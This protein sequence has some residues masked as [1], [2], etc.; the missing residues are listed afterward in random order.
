MLLKLVFPT[1]LVKSSLPTIQKPPTAGPANTRTRVVLLQVQ[2]TQSDRGYD[3]ATH[4]AF[5]LWGPQMTPCILDPFSITFNSSKS[6][7]S[8]GWFLRWQEAQSVRRLQQVKKKSRDIFHKRKQKRR[9]RWKQKNNTWRFRQ[10]NTHQVLLK[11]SESWFGSGIMFGF[12][13]TERVFKT[14]LGTLN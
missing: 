14:T 12:A 8:T 2:I 4:L 13:S 7:S 1:D 3:A 6:R 5:A 11:E 9:S 10:V